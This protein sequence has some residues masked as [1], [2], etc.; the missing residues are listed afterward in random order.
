M[1]YTTPTKMRQLMRNLPPSITDADLQ[2]FADKATVYIDAKLGGLYVVPFNP[3]TPII[4]QIATDLATYFAHEAFYTSQKP[5]LDET[6]VKKLE[7]IN[8]ILQEILNG[9]LYIGIPLPSNRSTGFAST[10]DRDPE[11]T[12]DTEW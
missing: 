2:V 3:V 4:E 1:A 7:Q 10:N 5:N 11:F 9:D 12:L 6:L 8:K